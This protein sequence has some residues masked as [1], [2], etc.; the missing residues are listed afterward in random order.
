MLLQ[1]V[2]LLVVNN[3]IKTST[4]QTDGSGPANTSVC[5]SSGV[6]FPRNLME[7]L[8]GSGAVVEVTAGEVG[9]R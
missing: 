7:G 6:W 4:F 8:S 5:P 9:A 2:A 1:S 3:V